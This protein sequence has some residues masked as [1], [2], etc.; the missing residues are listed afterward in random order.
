MK[1]FDIIFL[2]NTVLDW[3]ISAGTACAILFF[4]IVLRRIILRKAQRLAEKTNTKIDD[5]FV[6]I[7]K[8]LKKITMLVIAVYGGSKVLVLHPKASSAIEILLILI[9]LLQTGIWGNRIISFFITNILTK[10]DIA[11]GENKSIQSIFRLVGR[12][13]LWSVILLLALDNL[14]VN[15]TTLIAGLGIGGIAVAL[16]LQNILGDLFASLSILLDRPFE[17]GDFIIVGEYMG[18]VEH[19]GLKTTRLRSL[20]GEENVFSNTDLI[21]SRIRNYKRMSERRIVFLIDVVYQTPYDKLCNIPAI[22]KEIIDAQKLAR[23]DR[24]HFKNFADSSLKYEVVYYVSSPDYNT[25]MDIQQN[26]NL[27]IFKRFQHEQIEFAYPTR[28]VFMA[29]NS[30]SKADNQ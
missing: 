17:T 15:I 8:D 9:S 18:T 4:I 1:I 14:G 23:F 3:L 29:S 22:I 21:Q 11:A 24:A 30:D 27:E 25:Y 20:S 5:L 26:I 28:T 16:A 19:V 12:I 2:E 13:L 10:R 7:L 6:D